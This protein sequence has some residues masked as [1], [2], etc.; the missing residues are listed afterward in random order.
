MRNKQDPRTARSALSRLTI[1][2]H[3]VMVAQLLAH[4]DT[5]DAALQNLSER[6]EFALAP[7]DPDRRAAV[8]D[9]ERPSAGCAV[10]IAESSLEMM[11]FPT[12][13]HLPIPRDAWLPAT[14]AVAFTG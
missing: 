10:L 1:D 9:P 4:V 3:A 2:H 13:G 12:V 11:V 8:H 6:I 5:L 14:E 7:Q